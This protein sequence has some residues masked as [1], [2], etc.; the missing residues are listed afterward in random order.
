MNA[1]RGFT[2]VELLVVIAIIGILASIVLASLS[3]ARAKGRDAKRVSDIKEIQL[4][5]ELYYDANGSFPLTIYGSP[6]PLVTGGYISVMPFDPT[7]GAC[8]ND[9]DAGCYK[10]VALNSTNCGIS[11]TSATS[12]HLAAVL[13]TV[14]PSAT[15]ND[16]DACPYG[17]AGAACASPSP[18]VKDTYLASTVY[19]DFFGMSTNCGNTTNATAATDRCFDVTP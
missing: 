5:L 9:G 1:K 17:P 4:A 12:F 15:G 3:T 16:S 2:L 11:C 18:G 19:T 13:E 8:V 7:A 14:N 10:Y 6:S